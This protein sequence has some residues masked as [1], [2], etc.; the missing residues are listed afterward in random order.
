MIT[1]GKSLGEEERSEHLVV[2]VVVVEA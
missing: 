2:V 1:G